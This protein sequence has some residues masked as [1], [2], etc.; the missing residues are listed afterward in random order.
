[1]L[2]LEWSRKRQR[3]YALT[4]EAW[5]LPVAP[6]GLASLPPPIAP[7][8]SSSTPA[9]LAASSNPADDGGAPDATRVWVGWWAWPLLGALYSGSEKLRTYVCIHG[10]PVVLAQEPSAAV[11]LLQMV[12]RDTGGWVRGATRPSHDGARLP[13]QQP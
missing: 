13:C 6:G 8:S 12:L 10:L 4:H 1:M 2:V 11:S 3:N 5:L 9:A 7:A